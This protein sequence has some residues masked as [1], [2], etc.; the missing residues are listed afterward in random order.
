MNLTAVYV[1]DGDQ[2]LAWIE[3]IPGV[4]SQGST[5]EAARENLRDALHLMIKHYQ[6]ELLHELTTKQIV[7]REAFEPHPHSARSTAE[8]LLESADG[9]VGDDF[10][11]CLDLVYSTRSDIGMK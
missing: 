8:S 3:E 6:A 2:I 7:Q 4:Q 10:Q 1:Q 9:W 5:I 11:E